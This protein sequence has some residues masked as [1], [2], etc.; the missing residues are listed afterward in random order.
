MIE[1]VEKEF[2]LF[3]KLFSGIEG[4]AKDFI[5]LTKLFVHNKLTHSVSVRQILKTYPEELPEQLGM[6]DGP[7]ERTLY[8][9]LERIGKNFDSL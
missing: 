7:S 4:G 5:P 1:K 2:G 9:T 6:K 3:S 8:R